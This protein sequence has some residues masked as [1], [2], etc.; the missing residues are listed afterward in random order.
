ML[1]V[2][3]AKDII[4]KFNDIESETTGQKYILFQDHS[5]ALIFENFIKALNLLGGKGW[6]VLTIT[7]DGDRLYCLMQRG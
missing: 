7:A 5:K 6:K 1:R 2:Y 4:K 3:P